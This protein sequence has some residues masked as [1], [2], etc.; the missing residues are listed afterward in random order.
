MNLRSL[1]P[2]S[3][4]GVKMSHVR[5][6]AF[7]GAHPLGRRDDADE[8]DVARA[9]RVAQK[10]QGGDGAPAR[11]QHRVDHQDEAVARGRS[12]ASSSTATARAVTSSRW[13]PMCPTRAAGSRCEHRVE[14]AQAG[15]Q[16]RHDDHRG[17]DAAP[18]GVRYRRRDGDG[19]RRQVAERFDGEQH[20][21]PPGHPAEGLGPGVAV[22]KLQRGRRGRAGDRRGGRARRPL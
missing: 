20:A 12:A 17:R 14:H 8:P 19:L 7:D 1:S 11:G 15:P 6:R 16:H 2:W 5:E 3:M 13:R 9:R 22:A 21:D 4:T 10:V 18:A